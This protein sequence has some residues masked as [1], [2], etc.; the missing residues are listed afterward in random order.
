MTPQRTASN[1]SQT[2]EVVDLPQ[3]VS[4]AITEIGG[5]DRLLKVTKPE[6]VNAEIKLHRILSDKTRLVILRAIREC[7]L[8]PCIL[9]VLLNISNSRL[10][11]HLMVLEKAGLVTWYK[12]KNWRV[13]S[14]TEKG[15]AV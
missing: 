5:L 6:D 12:Q 9:K 3:E 14:I 8:C 7:D 10:S 4:D 11:Y 2:D 15:R 1:K 13:Y